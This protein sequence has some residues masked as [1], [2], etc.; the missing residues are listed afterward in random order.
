MDLLLAFI[1]AVG[2]V[3]CHQQPARSFFIDGQPLPVCARCTGLYVG[4]AAGVVAWC[5][6]RA[7]RGWRGVS[8][9]PRRALRIVVMAAVP[10]LISVATGVLGIWDGSNVTRAWLA[11]PLGLTAGAVVAAVFTKDLR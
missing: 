1:Y 2:A 9:P 10:T 5:L 6:W 4:A 8:V 7:A 3:V 11:A